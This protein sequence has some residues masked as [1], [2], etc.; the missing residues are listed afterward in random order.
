LVNW[1]KLTP[2]QREAARQKY[3][4]F[5]KLP[6][7]MREDVKQMIKKEQQKNTRQSADGA[8]DAPITP[9]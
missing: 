8:S 5:N 9:R 1:S 3:R 4:A 7:P 2:E 6:A